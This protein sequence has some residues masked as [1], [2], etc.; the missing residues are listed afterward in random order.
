[1]KGLTIVKIGGNIIDGSAALERFLLQFAQIESPKILVHGGGN[2]ATQLAQKLGIE[3]KMVDGRRI[4]DLET[5]KIAVMV[6]AGWI[7]KSLVASLQKLG[8]NAIGMSGADG[9]TVPAKRR[10]KKPIDFGYVGDVDPSHINSTLLTSILGR[11]ITPIFCAVT[12]D[13]NGTLFNT[14]ADT[15]AS[16]IAIAMSVNYRTNL[17]YC[18]EK[19][20]VLEDIN[21]SSSV[22]PLISQKSYLKL[23]ERGVVQEGMIPKIE[24][25]FF[26]LQN[27]VSK[28]SIRSSANLLVERGTTLVK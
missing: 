18:F 19:D 7:N 23:R 11:G 21:D 9:D 26:A 4:T 5:L 28:V 22:I 17:I 3:T 13:G 6:Y 14:N 24:N 8:C 1:M 20:G 15:M 2:M 25:A 16:S 12:H 27:N 10:A